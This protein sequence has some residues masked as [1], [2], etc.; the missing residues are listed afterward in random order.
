MLRRAKANYFKNLN[1][2]DSKKFWKAVKYLNKQQS[3]IPI[4][5]HGEQT[6]S[7]DLQ[8]AELLNMFFSASFNKSHPPLTAFSPVPRT[9]SQHDS[10]LD[11]MYCTIPEVEHLLHGLEISKAC[12]PDKIFAQM[13]KYTVSSIAAS[14]TK[15][16]NLSIRL[17]RIPD[18]WKEAMIAPIPKST[19]KS[20]DPGNYRPISLTCILCK[21]LEKHIY[22]LMYEH[23]YNHHLLSDSQWGFRSGRSTVTALL[24]VTEE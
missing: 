13:L 17:G 3:T 22:D 19:S 11:Q 24:S 21:L 20:S 10:T 9:S 18:C 16:F 4:L 15:L 2:R 14:V 1:P 8:K 7:T 12:G 23:L 5:Q 6:A